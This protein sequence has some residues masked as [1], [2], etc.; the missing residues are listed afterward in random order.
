MTLT[1]MLIDLAHE[2]AYFEK[3][4]ED[5][6]PDAQ[7]EAEFDRLCMQYFKYTRSEL[8]GEVP[9]V[10]LS[11]LDDWCYDEIIDLGARHGFDFGDR[12]GDRRVQGPYDSDYV[13]LQ[14]VYFAEM[15][16]AKECGYFPTTSDEVAKV[17]LDREATKFQAELRRQRQRPR[18]DA[19][20][21]DQ[22]FGKDIR[23]LKPG[24]ISPLN[25]KG[26]NRTGR[27]EVKV[28]VIHRRRLP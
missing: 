18:E 23:T 15:L 10:V 5:D 21:R 16:I 8:T 17:K 6:A 24:M 11:G 7:I 1:G 20:E 13:I 12:A 27:G 9:R 2:T 4:I 28:E 25:L 19:L 22:V 3:L 26:K 14:W